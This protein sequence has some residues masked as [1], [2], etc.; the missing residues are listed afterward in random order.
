MAKASSPGN[1][2]PANDQHEWFVRILASDF[3][4]T[5]V[6]SYDG[7]SLWEYA[8][9]DAPGAAPMWDD[10]LNFGIG[11]KMQTLLPDHLT[12]NDFVD[13]QVVDIGG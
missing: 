3:S 7:G 2:Y 4:D 13:A 11:P 9:D 12:L 10:N 8:F 6:Y 1:E 5:E